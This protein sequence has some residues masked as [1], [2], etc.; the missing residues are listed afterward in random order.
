MG[1]LTKSISNIKVLATD[2]DGVLTD[3]T[4]LFG[5]DGTEY[6]RFSVEDGAGA[7][8]SNLAGIPIVFISARF[9][10]C[11]VIRASEMNVSQCYQGSL[12]KLGQLSRLCKDLSVKEKE[13]AYIGDGLVDI[14]VL[15]RGNDASKDT[16]QL[17]NVHPD[18]TTVQKGGTAAN[19][20]ASIMHVL[21]KGKT[22]QH[23][24]IQCIQ[25]VHGK[26]HG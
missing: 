22:Q 12:D 17:R 14:H 21:H 3:S 20:R 6:K 2:V 23:F 8:Y 25:F 24:G 16:C 9:S 19:G 4:I 11:T 26:T 7:A 5:S 13:I 15:K 1:D 10:V 18:T